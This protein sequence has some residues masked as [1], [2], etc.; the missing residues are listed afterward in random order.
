MIREELVSEYSA[1]WFHVG[2]VILDARY[3]LSERD[4][5]TEGLDVDVTVSVQALV[6]SS[7]LFISGKRSKVSRSTI[8][9]VLRASRSSPL[10]DKDVDLRGTVSPVSDVLSNGARMS[11]PG[12]RC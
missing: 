12:G 3:G 2:L 6:N 10:P 5:G 8:L 1:V 11:V 7:Q 4:E 9:F